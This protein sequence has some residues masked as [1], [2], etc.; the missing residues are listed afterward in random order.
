MIFVEKRYIREKYSELGVAMILKSSRMHPYRRD[1]RWWTK[2]DAELSGVLSPASGTDEVLERSLRDYE[3]QLVW[4]FT[5]WLIEIIFI[6][7]MVE[8][9]RSLFEKLKSENWWAR[10]G[11]LNK[12]LLILNWRVWSWLRLNAGGRLNTCKSSGEGCFGN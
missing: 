3:E 8:I 12:A 1:T 4:I 9:T 6:D 11:V 10:F 5:G 2:R 7:W